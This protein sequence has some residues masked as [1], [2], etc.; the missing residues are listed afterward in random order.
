MVGQTTIDDRRD[1]AITLAWNTAALGRM[2]TMPRLESLLTKRKGPKAV[3]TVP[4][5]RAMLQVLSQQY[6]LPLRVRDR[7]PARG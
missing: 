1:Q 6:G 2:K 3:Q 7:G 5:Q 4:Q